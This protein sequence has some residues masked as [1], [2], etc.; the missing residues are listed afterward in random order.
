MID[1]LE[2]ARIFRGCS[3]QELTQIVNLSEK[4]T[5]REGDVIFEIESPAEHLYVISNGAV[6]LRFRV[7]QYNAPREVTLDRKWRGD[8]FGWSA[9]TEPR[10]Y[11]VSAL[12]IR[13]CELLRFKASDIERL[14]NEDDHLGFVIMRNVSE[15]IGE[16]FA[17]LQRMLIDVVQQSL[18]QREP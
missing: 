15:I 2:K 8:A 18:T 17:S 14:C 12:A 5:W 3:G 1:L 11:T 7:T 9:L 13:D 10:V 16:R 4:T 6:E